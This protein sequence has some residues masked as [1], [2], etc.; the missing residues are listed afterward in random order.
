MHH[1]YAE[2]VCIASPK[3]LIASLYF[4]VNLRPETKV[5]LGVALFDDTKL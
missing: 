2:I 5:G 1:V 4:F 3:V